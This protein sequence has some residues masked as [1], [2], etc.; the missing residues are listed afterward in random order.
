MAR[1]R[2]PKEEE[3]SRARG[4]GGRQ[5]GCEYRVYGEEIEGRD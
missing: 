4:T 3:V 2:H 1:T 5:A